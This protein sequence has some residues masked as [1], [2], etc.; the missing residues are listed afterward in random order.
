MP[1]IG[2]AIGAFYRTGAWCLLLDWWLLT[3][4]AGG[5]VV[6]GGFFLGQRERKP[7]IQETTYRTCLPESRQLRRL[8]PVAEPGEGLRA[9]PP[10]FRAK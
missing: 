6:L 8:V 4:V 2:L 7:L 5:I 3:Y 10:F 9:P 1:F